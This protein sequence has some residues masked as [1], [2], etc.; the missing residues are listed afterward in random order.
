MLVT[1]PVS[2]IQ[3]AAD[4]VVKNMPGE[5]YG[6]VVLASGTG[7]IRIFDHASAASGTEL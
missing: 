2:Y 4:G 1:Q 3:L 7:I 6:I 5:L